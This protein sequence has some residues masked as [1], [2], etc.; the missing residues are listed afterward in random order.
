MNVPGPGVGTL[1]VEV[2]QNGQL[3]TRLTFEEATELIARGWGVARGARVLKYVELLPDA[4]WRPLTRAWCGGS[5]TT[6]RIR[7]IITGALCAGVQH[8]ELPRE[9]SAISKG[10]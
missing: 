10:R 7:S 3:L 6:E 8:K 9:P 2:R 1:P 4:P 5:R